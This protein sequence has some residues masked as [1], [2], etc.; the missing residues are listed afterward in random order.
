MKKHAILAGAIIVGAVA[1]CVMDNVVFAGSAD[2]KEVEEKRA[3]L[4]SA[5]LAI[6]DVKARVESAINAHTAERKALKEKINTMRTESQKNIQQVQQGVATAV[7]ELNMAIET[8]KKNTPYAD[9]AETDKLVNDAK[10]DATM[11][12]QMATGLDNVKSQLPKPISD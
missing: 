8:L 11:V 2:Q 4:N 6:T 12:V 10:S 7:K 5:K 1:I 3:K 9:T